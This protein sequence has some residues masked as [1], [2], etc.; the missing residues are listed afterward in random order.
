MESSEDFKKYLEDNYEYLFGKPDRIVVMYRTAEPHCYVARAW[1]PR[2]MAYETTPATGL[3]R[4]VKFSIPHNRVSCQPLERFLSAARKSSTTVTSST[5][6][7]CS[8][9]SLTQASRYP[10]SSPSMYSSWSRPRYVSMVKIS[11]S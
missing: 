11:C 10:Y 3:T 2:N 8:T 6:S 1:P 4:I 9:V 7:C 5:W